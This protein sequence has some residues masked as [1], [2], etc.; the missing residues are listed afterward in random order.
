MTQIY[1]K[2][3]TIDYLLSLSMRWQLIWPSASLTIISQK[4]RADNLLVKQKNKRKFGKKRNAVRTQATDQCFQVFFKL[5]PNFQECFYNYILTS[6]ISSLCQQLIPFFVSIRLL[7]YRVIEVWLL[8]HTFLLGVF[9]CLN[10]YMARH[11]CN[12]FCEHSFP[13]FQFPCCQAQPHMSSA[14]TTK[15]I[16]NIHILNEL[17]TCSKIWLYSRKLQILSQLFTAKLSQ[18]PPWI[19]QTDLNS[20]RLKLISTDCTKFLIVYNIRIKWYS[21]Q[22]SLL[23]LTL[24]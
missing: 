21:V 10:T 2:P 14:P 20:S 9:Q 23:L 24:S 5:I 19:T 4:S 12:G 7:K 18:F 3:I 22:P 8:V 13:T 17:I 16:F 1:T 11:H 6:S 15:R